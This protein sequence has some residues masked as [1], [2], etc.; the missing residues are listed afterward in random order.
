MVADLIDRCTEADPSR[1][2]SAREVVDV[3][4]Q[5]DADLERRIS[6]YRR[7]SAAARRVRTRASAHS[8]SVLS[9]PGA[10]VLQ[11]L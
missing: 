9:S 11:P 1:R 4:S 3:L 10:H 7:R 2:P 8:Q 6:I 5:A